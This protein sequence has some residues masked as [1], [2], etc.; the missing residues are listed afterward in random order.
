MSVVTLTGWQYGLKLLFNNVLFLT[1]MDLGVQSLLNRRETAQRTTNPDWDGFVE[2]GGEDK[3]PLKDLPVVVPSQDFL[4]S[5][6]S[7]ILWKGNT[8]VKGSH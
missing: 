1:E 2:A 7:V 3:K 6:A 8:K 5:T 4:D